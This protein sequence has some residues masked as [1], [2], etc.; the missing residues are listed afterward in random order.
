MKKTKIKNQ[1]LIVKS[2][3]QKNSLGKVLLTIVIGFFYFFWKLCWLDWFKKANYDGKFFAFVY[4]IFNL[5]ISIGCVGG[6]IGGLT[7]L[8]YYGV[9]FFSDG[10]DAY[11]LFNLVAPFVLMFF[12]TLVTLLGWIISLLVLRSE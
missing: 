2:Q 12:V 7:G 6:T 9:N 11:E 3:K 4:F 5:G 1:S 10:L 8:I